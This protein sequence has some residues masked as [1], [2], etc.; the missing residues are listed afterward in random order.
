[1]SEETLESWLQSLQLPDD[2]VSQYA[3]AIRDDGMATV[4]ALQSMRPTPEDLTEMFEVDEE[5]ARMIAFALSET[6]RKSFTEAEAAIQQ[7]QASS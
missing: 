3:I 5:H 7:A 2:K 1:M 6:R 4:K